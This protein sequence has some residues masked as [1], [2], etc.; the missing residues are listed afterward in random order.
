MEKY[1]NSQSEKFKI[2]LFSKTVLYDIWLHVSKRYD[3][4][5][6]NG[7]LIYLTNKIK[8]SDRRREVK[9]ETYF[10]NPCSA[11]FPNF[12]NTYVKYC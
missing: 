10:P 8:Y 3:K 1:E 7:I 6:G 11:I 12:P 4:A 5:A 9:T 2:Q